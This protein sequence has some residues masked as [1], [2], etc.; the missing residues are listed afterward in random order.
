MV[1]EFFISAFGKRIVNLSLSYKI[2]GTEI[3]LCMSGLPS[4][5]PM[6]MSRKSSEKRA[7]QKNTIPVRYV[8]HAT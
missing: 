1:C 8:Q 4:I 7:C 3:L 6:A 2:R 5:D